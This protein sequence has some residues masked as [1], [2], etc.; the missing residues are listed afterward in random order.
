VEWPQITVSC[1][2]SSIPWEGTFPTSSR[3]YGRANTVT[4]IRK[5]FFANLGGSTWSPPRS[6]CFLLW[7]KVWQSLVRGQS[8]AMHL[9]HHRSAP[10]VLTNNISTLAFWFSGR[11]SSDLSLDFASNLVGGVTHT[12]L[13]YL[14]FP[15]ASITVQ[16]EHHEGTRRW[17]AVSA[18]ALVLSPTLWTI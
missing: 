4:C 5:H 13:C 17:K 6:T 1:S 15:G 3:S 12:T 7:T 14:S 11:V 18:S 2:Q 16:L 10:T 9:T 8:V